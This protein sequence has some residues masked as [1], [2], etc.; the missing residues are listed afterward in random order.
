MSRR[1]LKRRLRSWTRR[2]FYSLF[3]SIGTLLSHKLASLMTVLVLGVAMVL[4]LGLYLAVENLRAIELN[5]SDWASVT[6]FFNIGSD[7]DTAQAFAAAVEERGGATVE[8]ISP[9]AGMAEFTASS[10]FSQAVEVFE[11]NPLPWVAV[12]SITLVWTSRS[13]KLSEAL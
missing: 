13:R 2:Q 11:E 3:S 8:L 10:G 6:V 1:S 12:L 9:E 5:E 7:A 4:P